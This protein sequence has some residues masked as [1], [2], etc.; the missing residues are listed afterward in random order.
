M[1]VQILYNNQRL[2]HFAA[3]VGLDELKQL[4]AASV[5]VQAPRAIE[6]WLRPKPLADNYKVRTP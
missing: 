5:V 4:I 6:M 2:L 1:Q 3:C